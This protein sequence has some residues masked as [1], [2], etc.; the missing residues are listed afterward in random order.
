M[1]KRNIKQGKK[2][3]LTMEESTG[4]GHLKSLCE[5]RA[6]VEKIHIQEC[7]NSLESHNPK[8]VFL[9]TF[10]D[11]SVKEISPEN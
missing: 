8:N 7:P 10:R 3:H 4:V 9:K 1:I 11:L 2:I 5:P 6:Q